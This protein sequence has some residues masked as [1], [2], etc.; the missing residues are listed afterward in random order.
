MSVVILRGPSGAG[1]STYAKKHYP[2]AVVCSA[3]SFFMVE[4]EYRFDPKRLP[5][6]HNECLRQFTHAVSSH[7]SQSDRIV[8]DNTNTTVAEV[9][10][11]AA[12]ALAYGHSLEIVTLVGDPVKAARRN[13]HLVPAPAVV[14]MAKRIE[15][16]TA[17]FPPWWP[18]RVVSY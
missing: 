3:D 7:D 15:E 12:L 17:F 11:Y 13:V 1:K 4:G 5:E 8:V 16:Q 6:A 2:S 18:N 10:P 9:S 14:A